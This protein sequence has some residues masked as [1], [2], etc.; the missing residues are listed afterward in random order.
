ML[1]V[2][3]VLL[4]V[5]LGIAGS[6]YFGA[7]VAFSLL[8]FDTNWWVFTLLTALVV[9]VPFFLWFCEKWGIDPTDWDN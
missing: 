7:G 6:V 8:L 9:E 1:V 5:L 4:I 3:L 2:D